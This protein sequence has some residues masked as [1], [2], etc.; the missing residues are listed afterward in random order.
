MGFLELDVAVW[1][2]RSMIIVTVPRAGSWLSVLVHEGACW[3]RGWKGVPLCLGKLNK[4]LR[5]PGFGNGVE[6][7]NGA[8]CRNVLLLTGAASI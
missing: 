5:V 3:M 2:V 6:L 4:I 7:R 1:I 8:G